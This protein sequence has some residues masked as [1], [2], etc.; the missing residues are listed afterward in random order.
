M[1]QTSWKKKD[2]DTHFGISKELFL[3]I[4]RVVEDKC[5]RIILAYYDCCTTN[6]DALIVL[7][8]FN[9]GI[10]MQNMD[11]AYKKIKT[12][13]NVLAEEYSANTVS[14]I[15][16]LE[17]IAL[18]LDS[19]LNDL[20]DLWEAEC[21]KLVGESPKTLFGSIEI[22]GRNEKVLRLYFTVPYFVKKF[23]PYPE[24]Q[25]AKEVFVYAVDRSS[26]E[27][28]MEDYYVR[29]FG[30]I[31]VMYRQE[32]LRTYLTPPLHSIFGGQTISLSKYFPQ[33]RRL[34]LG[35]TFA[36]NIYFA[37]VSSLSH[38][39]YPAK[40]SYLL[41]FTDWKEHHSTLFYVALSHLTLMSIQ[42]LRF[43]FNTTALD[44]LPV[45]TANNF[46]LKVFFFI[47]KILI[48]FFY[49]LVDAFGPLS[50]VTCSYLAAF[51]GLFWFYVP[52]LLD[53]M[54]Q[55]NDMKFL[56]QAILHNGIKMLYTIALAFLFLYFF[57]VITII[58]FKPTF[59]ANCASDNGICDQYQLNNHE[60]CSDNLI[61]CYA[62]HLAYGLSN[63]PEWTNNGYIFPQVREL[64]GFTYGN[65][66]AKISGTVFNLAYV[67]LINLVLQAIISGLIIDTFSTMRQEHEDIA[68]DIADKCFVC[69]I[70]KDE[71]EQAGIDYNVH[72][73][74]EHNMWKYLWFKLY[75]DGKDPSAYSS[76]ENFV[77][78]NFSEKKVF[79]F[80]Y[81]QFV[82]FYLVIFLFTF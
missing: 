72:I 44:N 31:Y 58:Y 35:L 39:F 15:A 5:L 80:F 28:K 78:R 61:A 46:L 7:S 36:L 10:L 75:L 4:C 52:C 27:D 66:I 2:F 49:M 43:L 40:N 63:S 20:L 22:I 79:F 62:L 59:N 30:I 48:G 16:L 9:H 69:S 23:W 29:M 24:V 13:S 56:Y 47:L 32:A 8:K 67:I 17:N 57:A 33:I 74:D 45:F 19:N 55:I 34:S 41:Y 21:I 54:F 1:M 68:Q 77:F 81:F 18:V 38:K 51:H 14:Y 70:T 73:N 65:L 71:F 42:A 37:Y 76:V 64:Q 26:P 12:V 6:H 50:L 3:F 82:L 25:K 11:N 53:V 60:G